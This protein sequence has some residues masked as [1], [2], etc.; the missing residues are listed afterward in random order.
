MIN[1][2]EHFKRAEQGKIIWEK[3]D[4]FYNADL[5]IVFPHINEE[6]N[7]YALL[8]LDKHIEKKKADSVVLVTADSGVEKSVKLFTQRMCSVEK[9][10]I[11]DIHLMLKYYALYEFTSRMTIIS[12]KIPYDTRGENFLGVK[13]VTKKELLCFDIYRFGEVPEVS[14]PRYDL[15]DEDVISFLGLSVG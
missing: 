4:A 1:L 14:E 12:L 11:E 15:G 6:Y 8:Y 3:L 10:P 2:E 9:M 5:Y 7:Y 13:G